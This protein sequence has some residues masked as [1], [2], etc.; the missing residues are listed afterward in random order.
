[1]KEAVWKRRA[2]DL[3][4]Q[5]T[6]EEKALE[7][8]HNAPGVPRLG[9]PP[10]NWWNECLHG[11]ARAGTA[12]VFPQAIGLAAIFSAPRLKQIADVI[13]TEARAKYHEFVRQ[14]D[15][16]QYKGL[17]YW[18]PNINIFRD[19]RW[20]RGHETYGECPFLTAR[21]GVAF[22]E[23]LQGDDPH[24]FKVV[25]TPKHFAVHSGPEEAR[26]SFNALASEK[27]LWETYLPAFHACI[28]E[29]KAY[30]IMGAYNRTNGEPCCASQRLLVELLR[31]DWGF[32]G[33]VVSDCWAIKDFHESHHV[34]ATREESAAFAVKMGC[35]LNCG[36]TYEHLPQAVADGLLDESEMDVCLVRLLI[37]RM[38]LGLFEPEE[39]VRY[40][41]IPYEKNDC[42]EHRALNLEV[43]AEGLVLLKNEAGLLPLSPKISSIAVIGPNAHDAHVLR[44]NYFG[45]PS[46]TTTPLEG[47]RLSVS[48]ST[49]V[50]YT[51]GCKHTGTKTDG[52]GRAGNLSE[53][54]SM[55]ARADVTV[56]V[57]GLTAE[58]EG[59][60]GDVGNSDAGGDKID[61]K[62][63]GLQQ[64]LMEEVVALGKPVVLV[65]LAGSPLDLRW[66]E[67]HVGAIL[68]AW[69]PGAEGG[70]AIA[71]V[72]FG[73]V[74][75]AG[76]L[77]VTFPQ[78]TDDLP[79]MEDYSMRGRT[80][81]YAEK[82]PLYPFGYGRSF[83]SFEYSKLKLSSS[84]FAK[85]D[86]LLVRA[87]ITHRSGP[88]SDEVA[89]LYVQ[90]LS[91][92]KTVPLFDLRGFCR[93]SLS[94]GESKEI[95]FSLDARAL[96][97]IDDAG[98]RLLEPGEVKIFVGG[99]Q[100]DSRS[101]QLL[102]VAPLETTIT[103]QGAS[104][105]L[106]F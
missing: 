40:A 79:P 75:P 90:H 9:I 39:S 74:S 86:T 11:V 37:A 101:V 50:W 38:K 62:L 8:Q 33:F 7:M 23:G 100:P 12:T 61:L 78:S 76:R 66:A 3:V 93:L 85:G 49:R 97:V 67:Q 99:S 43:A 36:C 70:A 59:E 64:Q 69:Y 25:A 95:E 83:A 58:I 71:D 91:S 48:E 77:P 103:I 18:T 47:I 72:L 31:K 98:K 81:R 2:C 65:T 57:L 21:L 52:L 24:F 104:S 45:D 56:L 44:G 46:K 94:P 102:N 42:A 84:S 54:R 87:Q 80:Y 22:C 20:G 34:T 15:R 92:T 106:P 17:T 53:A 68:H 41:S 30:S 19:P 5:M 14:G 73:R 28:T 29:S 105:E 82:E 26:H 51:Q 89:Q 16:G 96:S 4:A 27:D 1:M 6:L 35:D 88:A 55:A 13:S 63:T 60:Q 10:Y 32:E